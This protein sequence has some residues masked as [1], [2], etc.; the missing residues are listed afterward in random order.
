MKN[1]KK[2]IFLLLLGCSANVMAEGILIIKNESNHLNAEV[3]VIKDAS[4]PETQVFHTKS[5]TNNLGSIGHVITDI[6]YD[7]YK[8]EPDMAN[9]VP[10]L[11][12]GRESEISTRH[13]ALIK[14]SFD[15]SGWGASPVVKVNI[16]ADDSCYAVIKL[17]KIVGA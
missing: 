14:K 12:S 17:G 15:N 6:Y 2:I 3:T 1:V 5:A 8:Q 11:G 16:L 10:I 4:N 9:G 7:V 13:C